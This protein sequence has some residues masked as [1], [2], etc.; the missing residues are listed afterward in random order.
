MDF[1]KQGLTFQE[2]GDKLGLHCS[3]VSQNHQKMLLNPDPHQK[4]PA[5]GHPAKMTPRKLCCAAQAIT[6]GTAVD[7]MDVKHQYFLE[8]S[9]C[10][11]QEQLS[12]IGLKGQVHHLVPYLMPRHH[13]LRLKW[14]KD[15]VDW[16]QED[17]DKV[18]FSDES[19][20]KLFG[21][22]GHQWCRT[23][24]GEE[25]LDRNM[26]Q[27]V[28]HGGGNVMVWGCIT[29]NGT[30][31]LHRVEGHMNAIQYCNILSESLLGTIT[32]YS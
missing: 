14:A 15:H 3:I 25:Y 9:V 2:I 1:H 26:K 22:D 12:D 16:T 19:K 13:C 32:D 17:W 29:P 27:T 18:W 31:R 8:I 6:S 23:R 7:A 11:V 4:I 5:P 21:S 28:K 20:F 30:G 24:P 10:T